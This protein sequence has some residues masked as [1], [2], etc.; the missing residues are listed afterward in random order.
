[1]KNKKLAIG[2]VA[3]LIVF[4][5]AILYV[6]FFD[7]YV[8]F[9]GLDS[10]KITIEYGDKFTQPK[11]TALGKGHVLNRKGTKLDL[12]CKGEVDDT[13]LG[14]YKLEYSA[15]YRNKTTT[16][17]ITVSVVD[18]T[19]PKLTLVGDKEVSVE[20]GGTYSESG[21][22]AEDIYDGDLTSKIEIS[23]EVDSSKVQDCVITYK[24][25]D[26]NGNVGKI[27]RKVH[28]VDKTAP[29]IALNGDS[30]IYIEKDKKFEDPGCSATDNCDGD[31]SEQVSVSGEVDME[32]A[33]VYT[34]T[35]SVTDKSGNVAT[36][37][38]TVRVYAPMSSNTVNPGDKVIYLTFDD[39]PGEY[40]QQLLDVLDKYNVKVTFFVT[41]RFSKYT[42]LIGEESRRG[43]TVA[44]HTAS[45]DYAKIYSSVDAYF[46]DFN[47]MNDVI[48]QQTG[49][50]ATLCRFPGGT[51]N[52]VSRKY[53]SGIMTTLSQEVTARGFRY[54]DWNV[55]SGDAGETTDTQQVVANVIEGCKNHNV[56][57]VLQHDIKGFSVNAVE[58]IIQW[59]LS[60]GYTFL[61]ITDTTP[62]VQQKINN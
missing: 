7:Y 28:V 44:V 34:L 56:S 32:K 55:S 31:I 38:R 24:V 52:T 26:S 16:K 39:G 6:V 2:I 15:T 41:N 51:S 22:S 30:T 21:C 46:E 35:Y 8:D 5:L 10:E 48:T 60:E 53:C 17:I 33:G 47:L 23:G 4:L 61:P 45:H 19:E 40:T 36:V 20:I 3:A 9:K 29:E 37:D 13:K 54:C 62:L 27:K 49:K 58:Q 18:T 57:I 12:T 50:S 11:V 59:G 1:M 14:D 25:T 43:H 42:Y